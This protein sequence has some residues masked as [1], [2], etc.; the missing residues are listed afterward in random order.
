M[1]PW[2]WALRWLLGTEKE[3][4]EQQAQDRFAETMNGDVDPPMTPAEL[5]A[6]LDAIVSR[7]QNESHSLHPPARETRPNE[8]PRRQ[9]A[10]GAANAGGSGSG[11]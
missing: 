3:A 5:E 7:V 9:S 11:S 6:K 4:E 10:S 2:G 1:N 8:Q